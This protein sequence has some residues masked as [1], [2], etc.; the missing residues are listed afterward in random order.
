MSKKRTIKVLD[1]EGLI[2]LVLEDDDV[3]DI[4]DLVI[5]IEDLVLDNIEDVD[6]Y[7]ED[8]VLDVED[9]DN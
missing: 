8:D 6:L 2:V 3:P 9:K 4:E 1:L 7:R 5:D